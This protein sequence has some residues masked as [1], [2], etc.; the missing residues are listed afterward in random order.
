M[1]KAAD[2]RL[3]YS[4]RS[5]PANRRPR[6]DPA[7]ACHTVPLSQGREALIDSDD[8]ELVGRRCFSWMKGRGGSRG[9]AVTAAPYGGGMIYLSRVIVGAGEGQRV[10]FANGDSLDCRKANLHI[11]DRPK[12]KAKPR[13]RD[14]RTNATKETERQ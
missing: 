6:H 5:V 2:T 9:H 4:A 1:N 11:I 12:P 7:R 14:E 8:A 10:R 13:G 3:A